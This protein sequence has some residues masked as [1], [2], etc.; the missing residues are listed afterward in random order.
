MI[1]QTWSYLPQLHTAAVCGEMLSG[2]WPNVGLVWKRGFPKKQREKSHKVTK[3]L[4]NLSCFDRSEVLMLCSPSA[5]S[6]P[7]FFLGTNDKTSQRRQS[8]TRPQS[9]PAG[10]Q[11]NHSF[12]LL[13]ATIREAVKQLIT[14]IISV[15]E[16]L[17]CEKNKYT[18]LNFT[19]RR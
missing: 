5:S 1:S 16:G 8:W 18:Q 11:E 15:Q 4:Q 14:V 12:C 6:T 17:V 2:L 7:S 19:K 13:A 9:E 3:S 10:W